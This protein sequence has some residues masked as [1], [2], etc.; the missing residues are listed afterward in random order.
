MLGALLPYFFKLLIDGAIGKTT[1]VLGF[2][3][4]SFSLIVLVRELIYRSGHFLEVIIAQRQIRNIYSFYYNMLASKPLSFFENKPSGMLAKRLTYISESTLFFVAHFPWHIAWISIDLIVSFILLAITDSFIVGV[5]SAWLVFFIG[6]SL[7]LLLLQAKAAVNLSNRHSDFN[8]FFNDQ[9]SGKLIAYYMGAARVESERF[10]REVI[11]LVKFEAKN[12]YLELFNKGHQG[13]SVVLL[14]VTLV[15]AAL[16]QYNMG[17]ISVGDLVLVAGI[18]PSLGSAVWSMGDMALQAIKHMSD[19]SSA[20]Q[21]LNENTPTLKY[22]NKSLL[23]RKALGIVFDKVHFMYP[24]VRL[25]VFSNFSLDIHP[26]EHLGLVGISGTGKTTLLKLLLRVI[27][28][29]KGSITV[30]GVPIEKL[31]QDSF[32]NL[33]A[34][35]SQDT[36]LFHRSIYENLIIAKPDASKEEVIAACKHA[37]IYE[38]IE[39]LDGGFNTLVGERGVKLSGGQR[40]RVAI[41]RAILKDAPILILDEATSSLDSESEHLIQEALREAMKDKTVI[42][43]AHRLS[44]LK[45][46]HTIIV[47]QNGAIADSGT[48]EQ[49]LSRPGTFRDLWSRQHDGYT[50]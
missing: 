4:V 24:E 22:G 1:A 31:S 8:G 37:Q 18:I 32:H 36:Y 25:P 40:Q 50:P 16:R 48:I 45:N 6:L 42:A 27:A 23:A 28:S 38:L 47:L 13:I 5:F 26:K 39:S 14:W 17:A 46:M 3:V 10:D 9:I 30:G 49:L 20:V 11:D 29:Q 43:I 15:Y 41:A 35:V 33:F 19:L 44:T 34:I 12:R 7:P 2:T 21:F